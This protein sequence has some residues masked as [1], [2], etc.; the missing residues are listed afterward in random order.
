[1]RVGFIIYGA[2]DQKTGGYVYDRLVVDGLRA[3]GD[4]V[5]VV[6]LDPGG[7]GAVVPAEW[8]VIVGDGLVTPD[9]PP[10][11][12]ASSPARVLLVHH[13][14]SW[15]LELEDGARDAF[16]ELEARVVLASDAVIA[17][18]ETTR[19]R[20]ASEGHAVR[21]DVVT[22]GADRLARLPR[23]DDGEGAVRLLFVG[24]IIPRKRIELLLDAVD[25]IMPR[26]RLTLAGDATRDEAYAAR[27]DSRVQASRADVR[28]AGALDDDGLARAFAAAD[29]LVLPSSYEGYGMVL[30]E[31]LHAGVPVIAARAGAIPEVVRD[32][33]EAL[34]FDDAA[35]LARVLAR[36]AGDAVLRRRMTRAA[37]E[38]VLPRWEDTVRGFRAAL[39][40]AVSRRARA[41]SP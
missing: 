6:S 21:I 35:E 17:T 38:R 26:S 8:D 20:L 13:Q 18:S 19:R 3:A 27:I 30:V 25:P 22:P 11:F 12:A 36:F 34:L 32:G 16:R 33:E 1:M 31:A 37:E 4:T 41:P 10:I 39:A 23:T 9:L 28:R 7:G 2:L 24:S 5:D 29:A 15:E 14:T 40:G